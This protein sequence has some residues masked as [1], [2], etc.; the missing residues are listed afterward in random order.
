MYFFCV[1]LVLIS[2]AE[3]LG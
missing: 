2:G 3:A 1:S